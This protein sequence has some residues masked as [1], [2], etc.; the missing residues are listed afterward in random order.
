MMDR[1]WVV[2]GEWCAKSSRGAA[3]GLR[4]GTGKVDVGRVW[5]R[6]YWGRLVPVVPTLC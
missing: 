3:A 5:V 4:N 1:M 2:C 6:H